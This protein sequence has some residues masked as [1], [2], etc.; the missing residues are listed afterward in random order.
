LIPYAHFLLDRAHPADTAYV[1]DNLYDPTQIRQAGKVIKNDL[2]E[3]AGG[4]WATGFD[5][6]EEVY[7]S[8][9]F[10]RSRHGE[11]ISVSY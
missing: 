9:I 10:M 1:R 2:E 5:L 7:V 8:L 11:S 4:W 3:V 6:W